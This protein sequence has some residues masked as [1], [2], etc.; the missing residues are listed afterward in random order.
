MKMGELL[1]RT[2]QQITEI[3]GLKPVAITGAFKNDEGWHV[4]LELVEM[5]R[6]PT[7][8][9]VLGAY[10]ALVAEDGTLI[11]FERKRIRLRADPMAEAAA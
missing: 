6:I 2:K 10:E 4:S 9:D 8:T 7:A 3:T 1:E 11:T 5:S